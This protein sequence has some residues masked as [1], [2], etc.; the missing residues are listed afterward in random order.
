VA[1]RPVE[2]ERARR[3]VGVDPDRG[4]LVTHP[5]IVWP[6]DAGATFGCIRQS[7]WSPLRWASGEAHPVH[8]APERGR[9]DGPG[10]VDRRL[11]DWA[12]GTHDPA[13][14]LG[15]ARAA[16]QAARPGIVPPID[17]LRPAG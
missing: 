4:G 13:S 7:C 17:D 10:W 1:V 8:A 3:T 9:N 12:R 16:D 5:S 11:R 2:L 15:S 6:A 14:A